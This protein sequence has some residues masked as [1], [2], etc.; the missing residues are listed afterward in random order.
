VY[1]ESWF[2]GGLRDSVWRYYRPGGQLAGRRRYEAGWQ[3][4]AITDYYPSG[5]VRLAGYF[6]ADRRDS[7]WHWR[8]PSGTPW[9]LGRYAH[10]DRHGSWLR[11]SP[12]NRVIEKTRYYKDQKHGARI[13]QVSNNGARQAKLVYQFGRLVQACSRTDSGTW[14]C[15]EVT[16]RARQLKLRY[17][18]GQLALRASLLAGGLHG[19]FARFYPDGTL[20]E[21]GHYVFG[22]RWGPFHFYDPK[23]C[24]S[25][26]ISYWDGQRHGPTHYYYRDGPLH[27]SVPFRFGRQHGEG[28]TYGPNGLLQRRSR[29]DNDVLY[30]VEAARPA[31]GD[32]SP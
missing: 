28:Q 4:G 20:M 27:R 2:D 11:F 17:P 14:Q 3:T 6:E 1:Q 8:L 26:S 22:R 31:E 7:V 32:A 13:F 23:G 19:S 12:D 29:Y 18:D 10:G 21:T 15:E 5:E 30:D 16:A 24:R 25:L 9:R